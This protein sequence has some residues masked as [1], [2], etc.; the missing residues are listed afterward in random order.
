MKKSTFKKVL[1]AV[2]SAVMVLT[3]LA[4]CKPVNDNGDGKNYAANNTEFYIGCSGPLTGGPAFTVR[5]LRTRL[6]WL[7]TRLMPKA[8]SAASSSNS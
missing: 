2:L 1:V 6:R 3:C 5:R 4:A 8:A 7:L